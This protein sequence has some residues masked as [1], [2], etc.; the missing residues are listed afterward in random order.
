ML[1]PSLDT[2]I[3][4]AGLPQLADALGATFHEVQWIVIGYLLAVTSLIVS[5]GRLGDV[6]GRRRILLTGIALFTISSLA[7]AVSPSLTLLVLARAFQGLGAAMM[8]A[9]T[10]ALATGSISKE[11]TGS[12]IGVLG[13]MSAVGTAIGPSIGGL[14]ISRF[15]W[16]MIFIINIPVGIANFLLVFRNLPAD[17]RETLT[18]RSRFDLAGTLLLTMALGAYALSMTVENGQLRELKPLLIILAVSCGA[19]FLYTESRVVSPLIDLKIFR[20]PALSTGLAASSIVSAV[21]MSTLVVGPFYLSRSL[22]LGALDA[23]IAL[24]VGPLVA[25]AAGIPA[26]R[27]VDRFGSRRMT[28]AG[29]SVIATGLVL[30]VIIS[31]AGGVLGYVIPI[32]LVTGSYALF[33]AANN[34]AIMA[35]ADPLRRGVI[36]GVL[37]LSRNLG[38]ISGSAVLGAIFSFMAGTSAMSTA[39]AGAVGLGMRATFLACALLIGAALTLVSLSRIIPVTKSL[40]VKNA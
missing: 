3:A 36:S 40:R 27:I 20:E 11:R 24:S 23:G 38:L 29:L 10:V 13:T 19:A 32:A 16:P 28:L 21:M 31:P 1:M 22:G 18:P 37:S 8:M 4:N 12:A 15:G 26:G 30:V 14:L 17:S 34:T 7:C 35:G 33:Q 6:F 39:A 25:A 2:S 9:L 5:A